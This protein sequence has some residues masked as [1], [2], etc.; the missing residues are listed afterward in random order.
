MIFNF[1]KYGISS[2]AIIIVRVFHIHIRIV[3]SM[4]NRKCL[5]AYL[6]IQTCFKHKA[7][8]H[9]EDVAAHFLVQL[10]SVD[11]TGLQAQSLST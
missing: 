7:L 5:V 4:F 8:Y 9:L 10:K 1:A 2:F 11:T 6:F 3:H